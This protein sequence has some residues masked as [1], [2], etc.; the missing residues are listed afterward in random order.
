MC[1]AQCVL[2]TRLMTSQNFNTLHLA[3]ESSVADFPRHITKSNPEQL[4]SSGQT[5]DDIA[6]V[7]RYQLNRAVEG[8]T[9]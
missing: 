9:L 1:I 5:F 8:H 4:S 7:H 6:F 2:N 3:D